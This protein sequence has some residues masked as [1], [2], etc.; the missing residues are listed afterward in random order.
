MLV[1]ML[2]LLHLEVLVLL[3][4][5]LLHFSFLFMLHVSQPKDVKCDALGR[6]SSPKEKKRMIGVAFYSIAL[7]S[8]EFIHM[9]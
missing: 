8:L 1:T 6:H 7:F 3:V 4:I 5:R 2:T 9:H